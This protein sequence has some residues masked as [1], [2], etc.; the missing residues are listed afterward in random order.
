M[1]KVRSKKNYR[2]A[3]FWMA[4]IKACEKSGLSIREYCRSQGIATS[5]FYKWKRRLLRKSSDRAN[6]V[7]LPER[8]VK[9]NVQGLKDLSCAIRIHLGRGYR[10]EVGEGFNELALKKV[11]SVLESI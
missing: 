6:L 7:S 3:S 8:L 9:G 4:Q 1:A 10:V 5:T 11:I 2:G